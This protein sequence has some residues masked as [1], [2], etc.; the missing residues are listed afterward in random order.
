MIVS[1]NSST[2]ASIGSSSI[3]VSLPARNKA[4]RAVPPLGSL[5]TVVA[6]LPPGPLHLTVD[7]PRVEIVSADLET[8]LTTG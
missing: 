6:G 3:V 4:S 8:A 5:M 2:L 1:T 7:A